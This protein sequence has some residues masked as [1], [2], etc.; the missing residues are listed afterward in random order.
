MGP[1]YLETFS[2][3]VGGNHIITRFLA[4]GELGKVKMTL[5]CSRQV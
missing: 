2:N 3:V 1:P 5:T 4:L